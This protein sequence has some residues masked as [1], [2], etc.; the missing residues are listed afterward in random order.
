MRLPV[1]TRRNFAGL[2]ALA[3]L[4]AHPAKSAVS[5][6]T[7]AAEIWNR[8]ELYFGASRPN[9]PMVT[10]AEFQ[11]F[12]DAEV[13]PRFPDGLT[14]LKGYGQFRNSAN[15]IQQEDSRLLILFYP[16]QMRNANKYIQ[17]IRELY[18]QAFQQESVLRV[19]GYSAIS[20]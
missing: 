10:D 20:F 8:T 1:F 6:P 5:R 16:P 2:A 3:G 13:T 12:L 19:D 4:A 14:L 7:A 11:A 9:L 15:M 18:K 17:E